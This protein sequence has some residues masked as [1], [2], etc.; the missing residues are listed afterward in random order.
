MTHTKKALGIDIGGTKICYGI[1]DSNGNILSE[2]KKHQLL[3]PLR[4]FIIL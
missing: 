3:K 4:R 1:V 2:I